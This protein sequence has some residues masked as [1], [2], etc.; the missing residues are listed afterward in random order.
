MRF[1]HQAVPSSRSLKRCMLEFLGEKLRAETLKIQVLAGSGWMSLGMIF[2]VKKY[3]IN[4]RWNII[5]GSW[6]IYGMM[7][8]HGLFFLNL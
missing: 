6:S 1:A 2:F 8:F 7:F 3:G 4:G 5:R